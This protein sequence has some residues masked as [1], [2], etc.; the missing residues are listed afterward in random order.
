MENALV[1]PV[2]KHVLDSLSTIFSTTQH[3]RKSTLDL[4]QIMQEFEGNFSL[5][6]YIQSNFLHF[7]LQQKKFPVTL[8]FLKFTGKVFMTDLPQVLLNQR[9]MKDLD[10]SFLK[11]MLTSV[12]VEVFERFD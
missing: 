1:S 6:S 11:E 4:I 7:E 12:F 3:A 10:N 5:C 2:L 8:A 9:W